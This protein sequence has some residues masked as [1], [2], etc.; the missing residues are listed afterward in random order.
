MQFTPSNYLKYAVDYDGDGRRDL[1]GSVPDALASTANYLK[2]IGWRAGEPWLEEVR[3]GGRRA[4]A[5]GGAGKP[6]AALV[7]GG[8]RRDARRRQSRFPPTT[9]RRRCFS[10]WGGSG[11]HFSAIENFGIYLGM[12][13]EL[14]LFARRRLFRHAA[15][16]RAAA[17][18]RRSRRRFLAPT[19]CARCRS[20]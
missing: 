5:G 4:L 8:R 16:R 19:R 18:P 3:V 1:V 11:R 7:L 12:E 14:E 13:P 20:G 9:C 10:R 2:A 17:E 15:R 6:E